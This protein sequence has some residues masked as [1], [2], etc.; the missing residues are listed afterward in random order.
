MQIISSIALI[1]INETLVIQVIS[2]LIL[3]FILNRI[4]FRP[5]Q[6]T[7]RE[8]NRY[9]KEVLQ[10]IDDAEKDIEHHK[11]EIERKRSAVREKAFEIIKGLE[12][13]GGMEAEKIVD[14]AAQ[15]I[16][17][18]REKANKEIETQISEAKK[19]LQKESEGLSIH[20][21]EKILDR[22]IA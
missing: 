13:A 18:L 1:S 10:E 6:K 7:A 21:I 4:M 15:D 14:A 11:Q 16:S 3:L 9:V 19:N 17:I 5:L 8:R 22:S 12:D 2:F 20:V